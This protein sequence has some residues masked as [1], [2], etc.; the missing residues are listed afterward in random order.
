MGAVVYDVCVVCLTFVDLRREG[1][2]EREKRGGK[3]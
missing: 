2:N 1:E 3:A